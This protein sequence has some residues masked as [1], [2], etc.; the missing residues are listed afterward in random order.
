M[1]TIVDLNKNYCEEIK[2]L[3]EENE[4]L[5]KALQERE[6][7]VGKVKGSQ[8]LEGRERTTTKAGYGGDN[9]AT[10]TGTQ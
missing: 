10:P 7:K 2:K 6:I 1:T 8:K 4:E 5:K 9:K 3:K